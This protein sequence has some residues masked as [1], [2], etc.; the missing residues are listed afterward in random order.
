MVVVASMI[1]VVITVARAAGIFVFA[2][3][4]PLVMVNGFERKPAGTFFQALSLQLVVTLLC[5]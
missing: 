5:L 3:S 1:S 2:H 4:E